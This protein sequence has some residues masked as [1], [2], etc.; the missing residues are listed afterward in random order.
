MHIVAGVDCHRDSHT[1]VIAEGAGARKC[2]VEV[3]TSATGFRKAM[4]IARRYGVEAWGLEGSGAL[5]RP[6]AEMLVSKGFTVY[7]VPGSVTKRIRQSSSKAGKSDPIDAL[8]IARAVLQESD[9]LPRFHGKGLHDTLRLCH[10]ER[11]AL[12]RERTQAINRFRSAGFQLGLTSMPPK[13]ITKRTIKAAGNALRSAEPRSDYDRQLA[14]QMSRLLLRVNTYNDQIKECDRVLKAL[15]ADKFQ[16]LR[17]L[18]GVSFVVTAGLIGEAGDLR[19]CRNADAFATRSATAPIPCSSGRNA[20][21]R[22]NAR[23]NRQLNKQIHT[24][25]MIQVR[26]KGHVGRQYYDRKRAEGK[27]HNSAMRALKRRLATIVYY[28]LKE[29]YSALASTP[30]AA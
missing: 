8:A 1:I 10:D 15:L 28:R 3:D 13:L 20:F 23:G 2:E 6:F 9:R 30:L 25:A 5:G 14:A 12:V 17:S 7:E 18:Q 19:N 24:I 26:T 21:V 22:L 4:S 16:G 11:D 27:N 29:G